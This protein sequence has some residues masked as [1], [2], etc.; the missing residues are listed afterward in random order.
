MRIGRRLAL[1]G[2]VLALAV[3][4]TQPAS[5]DPRSAAG[6]W[7]ADPDG[8]TSVTLVTGDRVIVSGATRAVRPAPGR[9]AMAFS[10]FTAAGHL[11]VIPADALG[12]V[13]SGRLDRR[14]FDV[15]TLIES[16]YA[17]AR[18]DTLPLIVAYEGGVRANL[19]A[20][21]V[22]RDLPSING[23]AISAGKADAAALWNAVTSG[24]PAARGL[25]T[26]VAKVWLDGTRRS[27]LDRSVAQI[28]APA[29]W[30]AGYT[31]TG[32]KIAV[33]DTGV[34]QTHPDLASREVAERNFSDA[35]DAVDRF[36][37]GTH[38]AS[39][40]AGTGAKSGGK[41]RGVAHDASI[42]DGKVLNDDGF[43][44]ES[45]IIDGMEWAAEQGAKVANLSLG[46]PDSPELDP[47]EEAVD[48]LSARHGVLF[49]IAAGN[50]G[51]AETIGS[52]GSADAALTVGAVDRDDSIAPFSSRGPRTGDGAI[53]PDLTGPGVSIAAAKAA[54]GVI[55]EPVADGYVSL[56]G[57]SMATPHVAGAAALLAQQHPDWTG[58][59]L[60]AA[61]TASATPNAA[62]TAFDQGS[63]RVDVAKAITTTVTTEPTN[64][65]LGTVA[66]P[67]GDDQPVTRPLTYRNAG[68]TDVTLTLAVDA[69]G[70]DGN[71][72]PAGMFSLSANQI[73]VPAG[74]ETRVD[75][76]GDT[77]A[78]TLDGGYTG[79]I[80]ATAGESAVT[81]PIAINREVESYTLTINVRDLAGAPTDRYSM[82]L[83]GLD[84]TRFAFPFDPDGT[85][86][87]RLPRGRYLVDTLVLTGDEQ[88][89]HYHL[90]P[91]P[92]LSLTGDTTVDVEA[93]AAK[94]ISITTP[95][96]AATLALGDIGYDVR[97]GGIGLSRSFL[98][99]DLAEL[100]IAH[101]GP[102]LPA[103]AFSARINTQWTVPSGQFYGLAWFQ[104][105]SLPTGFS[106]VVTPRD[107]ATLRADFGPAPEGR[108][109]A[110]FAFPRPDTGPTGAW[111]VL[112]DVPMPGRRTEFYNTEGRWQTGLLQLVE[113]P[114]DIELDLSSEFRAFRPGRTYQ[115]RF[116][117]AVFGPA[118]PRS[119]SPWAARL[120]D[121]LRLSLPLFSDSAANAGFSAV[122]SG[123]AKLFH[124][125]RLIGESPS[126]YGGLFEV[127]AT[128]GTYRL[129]TEA[130]R[131]PQF[132]V[133]TALSASWTFRSGH[134]PGTNPEPLPLPA[135]RFTPQ[136]DAANSAPA[137]RPYLVP[138]ILQHQ[139][140]SLARPHRVS[141]DVSYDEGK[142]WR[143]A[144]VLVNLAVLL[145]HPADATSVSLRATATDRNGTTVE[146]TLIRAYKLRS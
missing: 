144:D 93:G 92:S 127:P 135:I 119:D 114:F 10:T 46:G 62:L 38:V 53:K 130:T 138:L 139:S 18:R 52:P 75:L 88:T 25:R 111:A 58:A 32:V 27:T 20:G 84:S 31:G 86:T 67:H 134:V 69:K 6:P 122:E 105:G 140:G 24:G 83:L 97:T 95:D 33:L 37:H 115:A 11:Y 5:A 109:G 23:A 141:V 41:Y 30:A 28:G 34:D 81:T 40:A 90:L 56:S 12:L 125:G 85:V 54:D 73:T 143:R 1:A 106:R 98:T 128:P 145:H 91:Y 63:G 29:A 146:Q 96:P 78:G 8:S 121:E 35:P 61:L 110:R 107:L 94:P 22:T 4:T 76:T 100:S 64:V 113:D 21:T 65:S 112:L 118:F 126:P 13:A 71:P 2:T 108:I 117:F 82:L 36:G 16:G 55:G 103:E 120:G 26:G 59:R 17:D 123:S 9:T 104:S 49:V 14:L 133:T 72:A 3:G 77:R 47:L 131:P 124:N 99:T 44:Q 136:L 137:G 132:D 39:I 51:A 87:T 116:A 42:L 102:A 89:P 80:V 101:L 129:T 60:K 68:P 66:W 48:S 57:T 7:P 74:G 19:A 142:T 79:R 15:T 45:W 70:P 43:G 50:S